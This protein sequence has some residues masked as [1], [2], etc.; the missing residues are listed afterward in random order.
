M[1]ESVCGPNA[2]LPGSLEDWVYGDNY[3]PGVKDY[4]SCRCDDTVGD[5]YN[6]IYCNNRDFTILDIRRE[7]TN[8]LQFDKATGDYLRPYTV[9]RCADEEDQLTCDYFEDHA[10]QLTFDDSIGEY[11]G[12]RDCKVIGIEGSG[13]TCDCSFCVENNG[14][15]VRYRCRSDMTS[16]DVCLDQQIIYMRNPFAGFTV[17]ATPSAPTS[18][19]APSAPA[20]APAP[21]PPVVAEYDRLCGPNPEV[22]DLEDFVYQGNPRTNITCSCQSGQNAILCTGPALV[23]YDGITYTRSDA[24]I[25]DQETKEL[26]ATLSNYF[27]QENFN[28]FAGCDNII[29]HSIVIVQSDGDEDDS[30]DEFQV[31][32]V[33]ALDNSNR[34]CACELCGNG[35]VRFDS[36]FGGQLSS[37]SCTAKALIADPFDAPPDDKEDSGSSIGAIVG[38][39]IGALLF[40]VLVGVGVWWYLKR[41]ASK[42]DD[43]KN[44]DPSSTDNSLPSAGVNNDKQDPEVFVPPGGPMEETPEA[45]ATTTNTAGS[46]SVLVVTAPEGKPLGLTMGDKGPNNGFLIALVKP[47]SPLQGQVQVGDELTGINVTD[48]TSVDTATML[49]TLR[50]SANGPR[51]LTLIRT[52]EDI[53]D[54]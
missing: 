46:T 12:Y 14:P 52:T 18:P 4:A 36:C 37:D 24:L 43:S 17:G 7:Y 15:G 27:C 8:T 41:R 35:A 25:F 6:Y 50:N 44:S 22:T 23:E 1:W 11:G 34:N 51:Q 47:T 53:N 16:N 21:S 10:I 20:S 2:N 13:E 48:L 29:N 31:C 5:Q 39:I 54:V 28:G 26:V 3:N 49:D 30:D 33:V 38:G 9:F 40:L 32:S 19:N 42:N 45:I